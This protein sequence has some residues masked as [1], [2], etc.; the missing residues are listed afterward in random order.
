MGK[1]H[2][3]N[4]GLGHLLTRA[5]LSPHVDYPSSRTYPCLKL[6]SS[7]T[8]LQLRCICRSNGETGPVYGGLLYTY[9]VLW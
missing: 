3:E 9:P 5:H 4:T 2:V 1:G 6:P 7:L 8:D